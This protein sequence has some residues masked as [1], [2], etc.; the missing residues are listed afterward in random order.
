M[1]LG[2]YDTGTISVA[3]GATL[4]QGVGTAW[5][6]VN[7]FDMVITST[8]LVIGLVDTVDAPAQQIQ[9]KKAW[10]GATQSGVA[11]Q[12]ELLP[13][14]L[15][16][17]AQNIRELRTILDAFTIL[18]HVSGAAPDPALGEDGQH[19]IKIGAGS[20]EF[21][22]KTGGVW[23][24]TGGTTS[25]DVS[26]AIV[27]ADEAV[28]RGDGGAKGVQSSLIR[29]DDA[30]AL[31]PAT[32]D[33]GTLGT[34]TL[35][36]GDLFGA[37]G[38]T[39]NLANGN[40]VGTHSSGVFTV[41]TGDLRVTTAGANA[42][43]VATVGGTQT[44]TNKTL[45]APTVNGGSQQSLSGWSIRDTSAA[46][47][48]AL[49]ATSS[50]VLSANRTLTL[51]MNN[52]AR[53][54]DLSGNLTLG[55]NLITS[56]ASQITF[57]S[58]ATTNV[59]LPVTGTL[60]T[61]AGAET[62]TNKT[63]TNPT[64]NGATLSLAD[65]GFSVFDNL[66][67]SKQLQFQ[68]SAIA[69]ATTRTWTWPD[70]SDT[71]V[72]LAATQTLTSKTLALGS[73]TLSGT[74]AQ[75][76][77]A[78]TDGD[79]ATLAGTETLTNKTINGTNNTI[80]N[81]S[82]TAG[83]TGVLPAA[84]GGTGVANNAASTIT[85]SGSFGTTFTVTGTTAVTLPTTGTLATRAGTETFTN[86]TLTAPVIATIVNT[87]T[88]TLPTATDTLVARAT[89]DTLT[90]KTISGAS[91]TVTNIGG[92]S[93]RMGSDAQGDVLYFNGTNYVRLA[94]G[95]SGQVLTTG[96]AAANPSWTAA[97]VG[98]VTLAGT[99]TLTNK[100]MSG[101]S[102][103]FTNIPGTAIRM[104][105]DAQGDILY[106][107]GS[108]YVR[109]PPGTS[110]QVLQTLGSGANPQWAT[111]S[112]TGDVT[113]AAVIADNA[114]VRGDGGAKGVQVSL[115]RIDDSGDLRPAT[116]SVGALGSGSF[117]WANLFL[118]AA[119]AVNFGN[120]DI[121]ITHSNNLLSFTGATTGYSFDSNVTIDGNTTLGNASGD[122]VVM[123]AKSITR[124]NST[125][126]FFYNSTNDDNVTGNSATP[127]TIEF[128]T[129]VLN[130]GSDFN[131]TTDTF[132]AAVTGV[133]ALSGGV[134]LQGMTVGSSA[135]NVNVVT[136][137]RTYN[138]IVKIA[139]QGIEIAGWSLACVD[140][141]ASDTCTVTVA[142]TG[143]AGNTVDIYGGAAP[144]ATYIMGN[145][146]G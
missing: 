111:V 49:V 60:A 30:G 70:A 86:K 55:G 65:N 142:V 82:L 124:P 94:P 85:I 46:F 24:S 28:V 114:V 21:W 50:P 97:G 87:G 72:G 71:V 31:K 139:S 127:I 8:G 40:W 91:N 132:T 107:D 68:I 106:F 42:A 57:V 115:V 45:T 109:L 14:D 29:L 22:V 144:I 103:T 138:V 35:S 13:Y 136:G 88:L 113:A 78:L 48:V 58:T 44:L 89:T 140:M 38:F 9:L 1:P 128:D 74:T 53:T 61:L 116:S 41:S 130:R 135:V 133:Y 129:L 143:T 7:E 105:S 63:L 4:V 62:L 52:A 134:A 126:F 96:G 110:G 59:T 146:I 32:N 26:A 84:N 76:N 66:D 20:L 3:N 120:G 37:T 47:D 145:L 112:G 2:L 56:G 18:Y 125:C 75:F 73:N 27:I 67:P 23:V 79:F 104:G 54:L 64:I 119:G 81:V 122:S 16:F 93:I 83:V 12:I 92:A 43:S 137:N 99:Q 100:T 6:G 90:N 117:Q 102:N 121:I 34:A 17:S 51:D 15:S 33:V 10:G 19:A 36:W 5:I 69:T 118:G 108:N 95:T 131:N 123:N 39:L 11:Y 77:T 101:A 98:D 25:G 80:T 141:D